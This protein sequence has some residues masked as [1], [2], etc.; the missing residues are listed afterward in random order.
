MTDQPDQS[1]PCNI[2]CPKCGSVD[3]NRTY[4]K[5]GDTWW[6]LRPGQVITSLTGYRE[7]VEK[8]FI[9]HTCRVCKYTWD[10]DPLPPATASG[11]DDVGGD[12]HPRILGNASFVIHGSGITV[13]SSSC[14]VISYSFPKRS[15][16]KNRAWRWLGRHVGK[17]NKEENIWRK[18]HRTAV[19]CWYARISIPWVHLL[20]LINSQVENG[21]PTNEDP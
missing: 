12:G 7:K 13:K 6:R 16:T 17:T 1:L 4:L 15:W 5:K 11:D 14:G 21:T 3:I 9:A 10:T 19:W 2:P 18:H 20:N 8:D